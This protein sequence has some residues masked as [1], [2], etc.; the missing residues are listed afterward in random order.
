MSGGFSN[1]KMREYTSIFF[2]AAYKVKATWDQQFENN[3]SF[4]MNI[5][6]W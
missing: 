4:E 2:E 5:T 6:P 1:V 3:N